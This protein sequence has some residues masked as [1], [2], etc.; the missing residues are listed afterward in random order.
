MQA[1]TTLLIMGTENP[2][3]IGL[4]EQDVE[5]QTR[6]TFPPTVSPA[7]FDTVTRGDLIYWGEW[8]DQDALVVT[9][10]RSIHDTDSRFTELGQSMLDSDGVT[11]LP[12]A[13]VDRIEQWATEKIHFV[14]GESVPM[15]YLLVAGDAVQTY[16]NEE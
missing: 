2:D 1:I 8:T 14:R 4:L 9:R 16:R 13:I 11:M 6:G 12:P 15:V 5:N 10:H 3:S 7:A